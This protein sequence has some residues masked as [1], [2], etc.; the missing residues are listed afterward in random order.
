MQAAFHGR[1][2]AHS[3]RLRKQ[4]GSLSTGPEELKQLWYGHFGQVLNITSQ[5]DQELID[6]MP[7]RE[8]MQCLDDPPTSDELVA[9][10]KKMK[11]R[12]DW[13][14]T[15]I[16]TLFRSG[17]TAQIIGVNEEGMEGRMCSSGL[18]RCR[19]CSHT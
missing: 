3:I 11:W 9:A 15:R 1:Q 5:C 12:E 4:D 7:S 2:L 17:N 13:Y 10:M 19:N 18:E 8:T 14:L 6:E 16:N